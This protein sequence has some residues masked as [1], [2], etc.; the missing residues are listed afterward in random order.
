VEEFETVSEIAHRTGR[1]AATIKRWC[2]EGRIPGLKSGRQWLVPRGAVEARLSGPSAPAA[3]FGLDLAQALSHLRELDLSDR[4]IMVPDILRFEDQ[5]ADTG[6]LF[7]DAAS[8]FAGT[9]GPDPVMRVD[10]PKSAYFTRPASLPSLRDRLAYQAAVASFAVRADRRLPSCIFGG[11]VSDD[12]HEFLKDG[13]TGWKSWRKT[14]LEGVAE[15][16]DWVVKTDVTA[17][18]DVIQ[19]GP[20]LDSIAGLN[21]ESHV[22]DALRR[23]LR[24]WALVPGQGIPQGPNA[25]RFLQNLYF[26]PIDQEMQQGAWRYSRYMDDIRILARSRSEALRALAVLEQ[27]CRQ[28]SLI[29][30]A[31]KT[32]LGQGRTILGDWDD[33]EIANAAYAMELGD[34]KLARKRLRALL[35]TA[36]EGHGELNVRRAR[37]GLWR[38]QQ[39]RDRWSLRR[40]L[41]YLEDLG[42][43]APLVAAYLQPWLGDRFVIDRLTDFLHDTERNTSAYTATWLLAMMVES[44]RPLPSGW[45]AYARV[46][47]RDRNKPSYLRGIAANVLA[48]GLTSSDVEWLRREIGLE[49]DPALLRSYVVALARVGGLDRA[50]RARVLSR[51]P[52][53][54]LTLEWLAGRKSLPSLLSGARRLD[55]GD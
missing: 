53:L 31:K 6:A 8:I 24:T 46:V 21:P 1:S 47:T 42:P 17:Y 18:F 52:Q 5:L 38:I 13:L 15:G 11:R 54:S 14:V 39:L 26:E 9:S 37:F 33:S 34:Y 50:S 2:A 49:Y 35:R 30:S 27:N 25:S 29:L 48:V 51:A 40:V 44:P 36:V 45:L 55:V 3:D 22:L 4:E 43:V 41:A 32:T 28:R 10:L 7:S 16:F 19:H 20:L 12:P 23:M